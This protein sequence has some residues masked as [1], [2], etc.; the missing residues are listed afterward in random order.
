[1]SE[2]SPSSGSLKAKV[3]TTRLASGT[4]V[5]QYVIIEELDRGGMALVYRARQ[6]GLDR[7][8]ALKVLPPSI[9]I[10][11]KFIERFQKEA[12]S[13]AQLDH[14]N[15]V[16]IIEVGGDGGIYFIA[17]EF[18]EGFNLYKYMLKH[19]PTVYS[20]VQIIK[21]L[22]A[23]LE[24]AHGRNIIHRDLKLNN[25]IIKDNATPILIDFGLAKA[26][27]ADSGLTVSGEILGSPSYMSPEQA[28]GTHVDERTDIYSIGV[29]LYELLSGH[30]PFYDKRGYQQTIWNVLHAEV[31]SL[32]RV[33]DWIP[34][35]VDTIVA[36]ALERTPEKR[37]Q[38]MQA[39]RMDLERFQAGEPIMARLPGFMERIGR[40]INKSRNFLISAAV[41]GLLLGMFAVYYTYQLRLEKADWKQIEVT[42]EFYTNL[43]SEWRGE[44]GDKGEE[45]KFITMDSPWIGSPEKIQVSADEY[46]W[47]RWKH[48][49]T[50]DIRLDFTVALNREPSREFG[51]FIHGLNPDNGYTFRF[52]SDG[53]Y[54]TKGSRTNI[55]DVV[56]PLTLKKG[57]RWRLRVEKNDV[58]VR[59]YVDNDLL[60]SY[61]DYTPVSGVENNCIGF[62]VDN[63]GVL[64]SNVD[65]YQLSVPFKTKPIQ[66]AERFFERGYYT[67]AIDEYRIIVN[68]YPDDPMATRAMF[69]IGLSYMRL[70]E[71]LRAISEFE[72]ILR[73]RDDALFPRALAQ[74]AECYR[75]LSQPYRAEKTLISIRDKFP[76]A[77]VLVNVL[78]GYNNQLIAE[79]A[80]N[81]SVSL[82]KAGETLRFLNSNF[83][84]YARFFANA[85]LKYGDVYLAAEKYTEAR[86]IYEDA[87]RRFGKKE[88]AA[89]LAMVRLADLDA[90]NGRLNEAVAQYN[91]VLA[92]NR[93][94]VR[95]CAESWMG[96]GLI[97]RAKGKFEDAVTCYN[98]VIDEYPFLRDLCA[99]ALLNS[100]FAYIERPVPSSFAQELFKKVTT[101]YR[102]RD[103]EVW[104]AKLM[105][106]EIDAE[107]FEGRFDLPMT[108]YY[109]AARYRAEG[110]DDEALEYYQSFRRGLGNNLLLQ[111]LSDT[112][113]EIILNPTKE[114]Q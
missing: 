55:I 92:Q 14:P 62:Y 56:A 34:R 110:R 2:K 57:S 13:I 45:L 39:F 23:A 96:I 111:R 80:K 5:G 44:R 54:L 36:K 114:E 46:T 68:L 47:V 32:R 95:A 93:L 104:T 58:V 16:R 61:N 94:N 27:E 108:G 19:E 67:D 59:L 63:G 37:Y 98:Y 70:G 38:T 51:C 9:S 24:Y 29:M 30:N 65:V 91:N 12:K 84:V 15:I 7:E 31:R 20:V 1:M 3:D 88:D 26:R 25:V 8:V 22:A 28:L 49:M 82:K 64:I 77:S 86:T 21:Q 113:I 103:R 72:N 41:I 112:Q 106:G 79:L 42:S 52:Q 6:L 90:F 89:A 17:M 53:I 60:L 66:T 85:Y 35:D 100:G 83:S 33:H 18:I 73:T 71:Y 81:D 75:L 43:D 74:I 101:R 105:L 97:N 4:K 102:D 40:R 109:I 76:K 48:N 107:D 11:G 69:K 87:L 50:N 78:Y 10:Q 99:Q